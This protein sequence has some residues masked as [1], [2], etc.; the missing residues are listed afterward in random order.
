MGDFKTKVDCFP[1][2]WQIREF[3]R[4]VLKELTVENLEHERRQKTRH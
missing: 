4:T 2:L 3:V 1:A